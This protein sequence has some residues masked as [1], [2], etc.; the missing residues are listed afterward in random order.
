MNEVID[1]L[2]ENPSPNYGELLE[3]L[4]QYKDDPRVLNLQ[5]IIE[6]RRHHRHAA[7]RAFAKAAR[8]GDQQ[9]LTNLEIMEYDRYRNND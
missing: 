9:A 5:G 2:M 3:K 4:K 8:M 7:E 1:E 6:Y